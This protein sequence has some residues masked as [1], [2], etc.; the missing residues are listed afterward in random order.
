MGVFWAPQDLLE[1]DLFM[2]YLA[3]AIEF[4]HVSRLSQRIGR[5]EC[6]DYAIYMI[7]ILMRA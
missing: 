4:C 5:T 7:L 3:P 6:F 2:R 1:D